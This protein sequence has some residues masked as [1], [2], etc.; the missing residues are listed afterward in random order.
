[1][2]FIE[3]AACEKPVI[4]CRLPAYMDTFA[5]KYFRMVKPGNINELADAIV[6][7]LN[8]D[9]NGKAKNLIKARRVV[10]QKYDE[11]IYTK[12]LLNIYASLV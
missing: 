3:A 7:E 4:S 9:K 1:M 11:K 5:E 2:M 12:E 6:E 10:E 8:G